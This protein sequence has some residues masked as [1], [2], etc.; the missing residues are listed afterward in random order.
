MCTSPINIKRDYYSM[1][2]DGQ[3]LTHRVPCG[4]CWECLG[5]RRND[6]SFRLYHQMQ[7]SSSACFMTLTYGVNEREGWGSN[8]PLSFNGVDTL[9]KKDL[10]D[11]MKRLRKKNNANIKYYAVGEYGTNNYRP[12]YH[13]IVF[14]LDRDLMLRSLQVSKQIWK[15]GNVDIRVCNIATINYVTGY[16]TQGSWQPEEDYD[17]REPHFSTMSKH[18]GSSYLTDETYHY[19]LDRM[20]TSTMH[21]S[22]FRM[23]LP[24]YY[25][26]QIFSKEERKELFKINQQMHSMDWED[27]VNVDYKLE[28]DA[29]KIKREKVKLKKKLERQFV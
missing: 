16:I 29:F 6:W 12:H 24:R 20:E 9:K 8:P 4:K 19:H 13:L 7:V 23:P 1:N 10:Q 14:N 26:D 28:R 27:F 25:R 15:K 3:F 2:K 5:R 22:G 21:P 11:F 18:L 17:D